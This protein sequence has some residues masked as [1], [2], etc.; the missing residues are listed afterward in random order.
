MIHKRATNL[1][2]P[3]SIS[4]NNI[5][6]GKHKAPKEKGFLLQRLGHN[7]SLFLSPLVALP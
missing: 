4:L 7:L 2:F 1:K 3:C 6:L 5:S